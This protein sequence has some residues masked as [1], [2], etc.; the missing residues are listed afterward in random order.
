MSV[1]FKK[2]DKVLVTTGKDKGK[3]GT[4]I[5]VDIPSSRITIEDINLKSKHV[6]KSD[7]SSGGIISIPSPL[8]WSN[9]SHIDSNDKKSKIS[10]QLSDKKFQKKRILKTTGNEIS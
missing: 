5:N 9:V 8:H 2:G 1:K 4:I 3:T 6:K 10:Y 7:K